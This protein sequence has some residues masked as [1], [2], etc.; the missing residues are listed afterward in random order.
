MP[1]VQILYAIWPDTMANLKLA[2]LPCEALQERFNQFV[3]H[4]PPSSVLCV[5]LCF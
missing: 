4:Y 2:P 3:F 5:V 1:N